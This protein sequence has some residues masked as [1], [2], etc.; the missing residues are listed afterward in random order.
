MTI[1]ILRIVASNAVSRVQRL[2][3]MGASTIGGEMRWLE[4]AGDAVPD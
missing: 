3:S 2:V 1:C 4:K